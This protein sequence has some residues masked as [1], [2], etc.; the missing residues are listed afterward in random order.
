MNCSC[1]HIYIIFSASECDWEECSFNGWCS[2]SSSSIFLCLLSIHIYTGDIHTHTH[3]CTHTHYT[4]VFDKLMAHHWPK[5]LLIWHST[6]LSLGQMAQLIMIILS[7][8]ALIVCW[9]AQ[10]VFPMTHTLTIVEPI[11]LVLQNV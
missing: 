3:T 11:W 5:E 9:L 8:T 7:L 2:S 10:Y 4:S 1:K 6:V